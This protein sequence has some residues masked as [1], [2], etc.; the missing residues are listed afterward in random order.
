MAI[1]G[2]CS[3]AKNRCLRL[4]E[5]T[6]KMLGKIWINPAIGLFHFEGNFTL[7]PLEV[8]MGTPSA[9]L[10][11]EAWNENTQCTWHAGGSLWR[12]QMSVCGNK[13]APV[14]HVILFFCLQGTFVSEVWVLCL[15]WNALGGV[16]IRVSSFWHQM[17]HTTYALCVWAKSTHALFSREWSA[18][19]VSYFLWESSAL[20]CPFSLENWA[21][22]CPPIICW[23]GSSRCWGSEE[24]EI[25]GIADGACWRVWER[26]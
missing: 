5:G 10:V 12:K 19:I 17:T 26:N 20:V 1:W 8:A 3:N 18:F 22:I 16:P 4:T 7:H 2:K 13:R 24:T 25:V 15:L 23:L 21:I 14:E 11:S 9:W 6:L